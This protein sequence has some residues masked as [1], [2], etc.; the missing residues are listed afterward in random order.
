MKILFESE[1][2]HSKS[3]FGK[4]YHEVISRLHAMD[5]YEIAEFASYGLVGDKET[6]DIPWRYYPNSVLG[7]DPRMEQYASSKTH[8]FGGWRFDQVILDFKPDIVIGC[9]DPWQMLHHE[10]S[11]GRP[12]FHRV[13]MPTVDSEPQRPEWLHDFSSADAVFAYN[14]WGLGVL[15]TAADN[16][17]N[18]VAA[19][20]PATDPDVYRPLDKKAVR[21]KYGVRDDILVVG[22]VMRNQKRKL[23]PD[24]LEAFRELLDMSEGDIADSTYLYLHTSYP[25][26]QGWN[27]PSLLNHYGIASKVLF[28]YK[29]QKC[30]HAFASFFNDMMCVCVSCNQLACMMTSPNNGVSGEELVEIYNLFNVYVQYAKAAGHEMPIPEAAS[31]GVYPMAMDTCAMVDVIR[32]CGGQPLKVKKHYLEME[33][34][35]YRSYPDNKFTAK[36]LHG[37]LKQPVEMQYGCGTKAR[38]T[39]MKNYG[40][41]KTAKIW[42]DYF[43]NVKLNN[44]P[45][46]SP[47]RLINIPPPRTGGCDNHAFLAWLFENVL[48]RH[49]GIVDTHVFHE[50]LENLNH[51]MLIVNGQTKTVTREGL[52]NRCKTLGEHA[53]NF[54]KIRCGMT[55]LTREDY[56][57]YG[58]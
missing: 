50:T 32:K 23:I 12:Y 56:L 37:F 38:Q 31:C 7:D 15:K 48:G 27:L 51:G 11:P 49:P 22:S 43:D 34:H 39:Y 18:A 26:K 5:K 6:H 24:L 4:Y 33:T 40:W 25:D 19:A 54:E 52:Y 28:T 45:Y 53:N 1:A 17:V 47:P 16:T 14:E 46:D 3:G 10:K 30:G 21:N 9:R 35:A 41:D 44:K 57:E 8:E 58:Q 55:E 2:S 36:K 42:A 13:V 20:P 29:C